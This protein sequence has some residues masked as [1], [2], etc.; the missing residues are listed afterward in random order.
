MEDLALVKIFSAELDFSAPHPH[1][2]PKLRKKRAA[3]CPDCESAWLDC[4]FLPETSTHTGLTPYPVPPR[5]IFEPS[6]AAATAAAL[7][8]CEELL[9][10]LLTRCTLKNRARPTHTY[11]EDEQRSS[12]LGAVKDTLKYDT[13]SMFTR[14]S[15]QSLAS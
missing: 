1:S 14:G 11:R 4:P 3:G 6:A 5:L 10:F 2:I 8:G 9:C 7:C 13:S 12:R 15:N